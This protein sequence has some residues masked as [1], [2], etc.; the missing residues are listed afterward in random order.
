MSSKNH[1]KNDLSKKLTEEN[2]LV[3]VS[4]FLLTITVSLI[5]AGVSFDTTQPVNISDNDASTSNVR[6]EDATRQKLQ[7]S[8]VANGSNVYVV[9]INHTTT[10][11]T[12]CDDDPASD[13]PKRHILCHLLLLFVD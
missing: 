13:F 11:S 6:F 8:L 12:F 5:Y 1:H 3:I 4:V 2:L 9:W 7:Q 10:G